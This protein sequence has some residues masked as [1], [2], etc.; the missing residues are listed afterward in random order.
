ME[1]DNPITYFVNTL[2]VSCMLATYMLFTVQQ[3]HLSL[4]IKQNYF[5]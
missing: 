1:K 4:K 2:L 3:Q 5:E